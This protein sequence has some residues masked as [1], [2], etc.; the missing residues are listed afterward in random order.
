MANETTTAG[1]PDRCLSTRQTAR[2]FACSQS[3]VLA[4]I[5]AGQL[6][7]F[8]ISGSPRRPQYRVPP[9]AIAEF[10]AAHTAAK[11]KTERRRRAARPPDWEDRY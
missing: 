1:P 10:E 11:P 5:A 9:S 3:K 6:K 7:A 4:W 2:Y 8:D